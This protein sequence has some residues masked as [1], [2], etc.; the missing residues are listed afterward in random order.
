MIKPRNVKLPSCDPYLTS[1][2]NHYYIAEAVRA[3]HEKNSM[4]AEHIT[5]S[6]SILKQCQ[7]AIDQRQKT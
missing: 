1:K 7:E 5:T 3:M 2:N 6:I 4:A